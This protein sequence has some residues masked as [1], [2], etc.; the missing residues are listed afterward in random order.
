VVWSRSARGF[1]SS[2]LACAAC[3]AARRPPTPAPPP[4]RASTIAS[5]TSPTL[6]TSSIVLSTGAA[7]PAVATLAAGRTAVLVRCT[8]SA[9]TTPIATGIHWPERAIAP[10]SV[11]ATVCAAVPEPNTMPPAVGRTTVCT[12]SLTLSSAGILSA[13]TSTTSNTATIASTQPFASHDHPC[14]SVITSV[15][16]ASSPRIS[17]GMYALS[18]AA[19]ANPNPVS[20][21]SINRSP[22]LEGA[23][24]GSA[25]S[26]G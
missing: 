10:G 11:T 23:R 26:A 4:P 5:A 22:G 21:C 17:I 20:S 18:P 25:P 14:G 8:T 7:T 16:R 1:G 6:V 9:T 15:N 19:V 13:I 2:P 3:A 24:R 12:A